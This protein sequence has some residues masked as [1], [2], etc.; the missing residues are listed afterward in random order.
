[1]TE[2][3]L[4]TYRYTECGLDNVFIEGMTIVEDHSGEETVTI[5]AIGALHRV[6]CEGI[7]RLNSKMTGQELRFLRSETGLT[8]A[9]LAE[10]V[11]VTPLTVSRWEREEHPIDDAAEMLIRIMAIENLALEVRL[12][13][14]Q[15]SASV[16]HTPR[17]EPIRINGA[18]PARYQL[19]AA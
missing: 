2:A 15:V 6:I 8:Q 9:R 18:D 4:A 7:V 11:K 16:T 17:S 19:S 12:N 10:I 5:P 13:V 14:E 1:M 3:K